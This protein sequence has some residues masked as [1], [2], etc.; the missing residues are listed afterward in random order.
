MSLGLLRVNLASLA[1]NVNIWTIS[2]KLRMLEGISM[3]ETF[4][5]FL[6]ELDEPFSG[7]VLL[8]AEILRVM[9][10]EG[11]SDAQVYEM[12]LEKLLDLFYDAYLLKASRILS[13]DSNEA[14]LKKLQLHLS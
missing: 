10:K 3:R 5:T 9:R 6:Q 7:K 11:F 4:R 12:P 13:R 2:D 14:F 1:Q 8:E